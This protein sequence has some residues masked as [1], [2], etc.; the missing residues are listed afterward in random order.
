MYNNGYL[1]NFNIYITIV[2]RVKEVICYITQPWLQNFISFTASNLQKKF[3][4]C[5]HLFDNKLLKF[6]VNYTIFQNY[7]QQ[8]VSFLGFLHRATY[9]NYAGCWENSSL[10]QIN[11][12]KPLN[13]L[14][15]Y[16]IFYL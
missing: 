2:C 1:H 12:D 9:H 13:T 10:K 11:I 5:H 8:P 6:H 14:L 15:S 3:I 16:I 7:L 4:I